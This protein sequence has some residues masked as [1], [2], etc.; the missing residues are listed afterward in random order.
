MQAAGLLHHFNIGNVPQGILHDLPN[1]AINLIL[2][3]RKGIWHDLD[4]FVL[5]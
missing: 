4:K 2:L 3:I 5:Y 1:L